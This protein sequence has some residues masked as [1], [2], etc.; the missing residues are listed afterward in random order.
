MIIICWKHGLLGNKADGMVEEIKERLEDMGAYWKLKKKSI[1][2]LNKIVII[3]IQLDASKLTDDEEY[4][5]RDN[6]VEIVRDCYSTKYVFMSTGG[7]SDLKNNDAFSFHNG[8][9]YPVNRGISLFIM[10]D[11]SSPINDW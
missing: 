9:P 2:S 3:A 5:I 11:R 8:I 4:Y 10:C 6:I 1:S 7:I